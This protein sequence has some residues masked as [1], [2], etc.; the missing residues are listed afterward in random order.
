MVPVETLRALVALERAFVMRGL[1][2]TAVHLMQLS[3]VPAIEPW[4]H[5]TRKAMV[6]SANHGHLAARAVHV[7]HDGARDAGTINVR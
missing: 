5:A 1:L 4:H 3:T 6:Q 2:L 7:G